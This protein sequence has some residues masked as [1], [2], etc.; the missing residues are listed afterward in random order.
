MRARS[1]IICKAFP[2]SDVWVLLD[3]SGI[4]GVCYGNYRFCGTS[5]TSYGP[6]SF[7][8]QHEPGDYTFKCSGR[9]DLSDLADAL[10][11]SLFGAAELPLGI[12]TAFAG[13]PFFLYLMIRN[14]Y[15]GEIHDTSF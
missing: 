8:N 10:A 15:G 13:A 3:C 12:V 11:R 2:F 9:R 7:R 4:A 6:Y 14:G 5:G 1:G